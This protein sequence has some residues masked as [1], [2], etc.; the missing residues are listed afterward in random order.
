MR[1]DFTQSP[2]TAQSA[3]TRR[4]RLTDV[5]RCG[6]GNA[7]ASPTPRSRSATSMPYSGPASAYSQIGK[8]DR[9]LFRRW[10]TTRAAINGRK[11]DFISYDDGYSPPKTVEQAR[12]LVESDEVLLIFN[13]RWARRP[14]RRS[15]KYMNAKK[16]P[17]L[18]VAT[19]AI[20]MRRPEALPVD[21]GLAA[22]LRQPR[23]RSTPATSSRTCPT[24]RSACSTRTTITA[25]TISTASRPGSATRPIDDRRRRSPTRRPIRRSI[26]RSI[27]LKASGA[28]V[29]FNVATPKFAAQ[30]IKKAAEIGWKPTAICSTACRIRSARC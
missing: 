23:A 26:R 3:V 24:P 2:A 30:A 22:R 20:E 10:S 12:K 7:P 13:S 18:F 16:V 1:H 21:H 28:D 19:G 17:Q 6:A 15:S 8:T 25:R 29:F 4:R 5:G 11:I 14:T 9:R 27:N